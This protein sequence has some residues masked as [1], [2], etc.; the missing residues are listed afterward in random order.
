M[1]SIGVD[2]Y[3]AVLELAQADTGLIAVVSTRIDMQHRYGQD[4]DDWD[5]DARSLTL[6]PVGGAP[7]WD[8]QVQRIQIEARC[9]GDTPADAGDVYRALVGFCRA[10]EGEKIA[11][12]G[13]SALI[14]FVLPVSAPRLILENEIRPQGGM[15][16]YLVLLQAEVAELLVT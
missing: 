5:L 13:G 12:T 6:T 16:Y 1:S 15:P 14:Y 7:E 3:E 10:K 9:Y 8:D 2:P 11:V 4:T